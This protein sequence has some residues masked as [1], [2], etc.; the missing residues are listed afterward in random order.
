MDQA[1]TPVN[2]MRADY[3]H[4]A[5]TVQQIAMDDVKRVPRSKEAGREDPWSCESRGTNNV[6][7]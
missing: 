1:C 5:S 6:S 3:A 2:R 7:L 4:H